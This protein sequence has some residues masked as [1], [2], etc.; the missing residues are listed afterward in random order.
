MGLSVAYRSGGHERAVL[1]DLS[2]RIGPGEA[3]GLVGESGCGKSTAALAIVRYLPVNGQVKGGT[4]MID[5]RDMLALPAPQLREARASVVSMVYQ[6]PA[7][8][9]NPSLT[10]GMQVAEAFE[11]AQPRLSR[12]QALRA[13]AA[14]LA[15]VRIAQP[16]RVLDSFPHQLSGG[17]QQR[18]VIAMALASDPALLILDEPTTG[19]D[20][21]IEAQ[22]LDLIDELRRDTSMAV[23]FISHNVTLIGAMCERVGVLYAGKLVEEGATQDVFARPRH[24][25]TVGLLRCLPVAS[26]TAGRLDPIPGGL[27]APGAREHGCVY[28]DRCALAQACCREQAPPPYRIASAHGAQMA[29]CHFHEQA[30]DLPRGSDALSDAANRSL[31]RETPPRTAPLLRLNR[32]SKTFL[33]GGEPLRA[34]VD[35]TLDLGHGETLGLVGESGSGKTTLAKLL[36]GVLAPDPGGGTIEFDGVP[37]RPHV[38]RRT[39]AQIDGLQIIFQNPDSALNRAHS[40]RRL[41]GRALTRLARLRGAAR[42]ARAGELADAVRLPRRYLPMRARH[43]SGGM[44]QRVAIA[45]A[46]AG[47]P[48][49]VVCDEPTSALDVSVQAAILNLL[50]DLQRERGVSYLLISH[51]L[52]VVRYLADRVAVLYLGCLVE[53]GHADLVFDGPHHPYTE[54][55]LSSAPRPGAAR[56][57]APAPRAHRLADTPADGPPARGCVFQARCPRK[58]GDLCERET[59]PFADHGDGHAIRCH[60]PLIELHA[61]QTRTEGEP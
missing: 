29:R 57:I 10:I 40:A 36:L 24:P 53:I 28:A 6:D 51:D 27:P 59:P 50:A 5:G 4:V 22:V 49:V 8:A 23:L 26:H 16:E 13:S 55:L 39:G 33:R 61:L 30:I 58:L 12:T 25:Y 41:I 2:L 43:L 20:A 32:V 11:A 48:R 52:A 47:E 56:R 44:K 17:M 1:H 18:V 31:D 38:T 45:R 54:A 21:T 37:L 34:L 9:L 15:R 7:R 35:V 19:L 14:M 3:Y 60:I 42:D 46:F